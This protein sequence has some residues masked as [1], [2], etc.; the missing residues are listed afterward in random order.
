VSVAVLGTGSECLN[1]FAAAAEGVDSTVEYPFSVTVG[2][3]G[4]T[5]GS[6]NECR[7]IA[8]DAE[9]V[10]QQRLPVWVGSVVVVGLSAFGLNRGANRRIGGAVNPVSDTVVV[11]QL[12]AVVV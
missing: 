2:V 8:T 11:P 10:V 7:K 12:V 3:C 4:S 1:T 6:A 5:N 9:I